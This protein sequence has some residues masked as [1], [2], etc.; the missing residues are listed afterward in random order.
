MYGFMFTSGWV[1]CDVRSC[2]TLL[3]QRFEASRLGHRSRPAAQQSQHCGPTQAVLSLAAESSVL[4]EL[5]QRSVFVD[6]RPPEKADCLCWRCEYRR[7]AFQHFIA[8]I[9][10][11]LVLFANLA[12]HKGLLFSKPQFS[13]MCCLGLSHHRDPRRWDRDRFGSQANYHTASLLAKVFVPC[14]H[15]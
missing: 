12:S 15:N 13:C 11:N 3:R 7:L 14:I 1:G 5:Q 9:K 4:L 10:C 6:S 8:F 2:V